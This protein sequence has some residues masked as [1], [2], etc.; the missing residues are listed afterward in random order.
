MNAEQIATVLVEAA[1]KENLIP[2]SIH[3]MFVKLFENDKLRQTSIQFTENIP[4][5]LVLLC[6]PLMKPAIIVGFAIGVLSQMTEEQYLALSKILTT[7]SKA[8]VDQLF[9]DLHLKTRQS[10]KKLD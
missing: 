9:E 10:N 3:E 6:L 8:A 5:P 1:E 2:D 7:D 4:G